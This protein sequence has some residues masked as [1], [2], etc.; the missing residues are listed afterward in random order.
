MM[1]MDIHAILT[2]L[3]TMRF[4]NAL[5]S[6]LSFIAAGI[7]LKAKFR[8]CVS[9][10][11]GSQ[12]DGVDGCVRETCEKVEYPHD[13]CKCRDHANDDEDE[14]EEVTGKAEKEAAARLTV[15]LCRQSSA[16]E[17]RDSICVVMAK[18]VHSVYE[19]IVHIIPHSLPE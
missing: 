4:I 7:P 19:I 12:G 11:A 6:G 17:D 16:R 2:A 15:P 13:W 14:E 10:R 9:G 1:C 5:A 8:F 3:S 18:K